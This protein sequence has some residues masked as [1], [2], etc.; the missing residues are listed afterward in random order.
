M[1]IIA[2]GSVSVYKKEGQMQLYVQVMEQK[3]I[4]QLFEELE[5]LKKKLAEEGLFDAAHKKELPFL[6]KKIGIITS[7][8]GAVIRDMMHVLN[9]RFPVP[10]LL[11]PVTVQGETSAAETI[12]GIT[13]FNERKDVD[14]IILGRGGGSAE[15]LWAYQNE[16]L[17]RAIYNSRIAVI[18]AVGHETDFSISDFV[19]D[20]RAP[21]PSAAAELAV[22]VR[23]EII[24][25]VDALQVFLKRALQ[26]KL[27]NLRQRLEALSKSQAL[28]NPRY[29]LQQRTQQVDRAADLLQRGIK[30]VFAEKVQEFSLA[31]EKLQMLSPTGVLKRGY[32]IVRKEKKAV[33]SVAQL[34]IGETIDVTFYDGVAQSSVIKKRTVEHDSEEE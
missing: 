4:G 18:S 6:P 19:A 30:A 5:K 14:L 22:P 8:T 33:T 27:S 7:P 15:D 10:V 25:R 9:R 11:F 26:N 34:N 32:A 17:A 12:A 24:A 20:L 16:E 13:Y 29:I 2:H 23:E 28:H 31:K 1:H 3:G 21:T